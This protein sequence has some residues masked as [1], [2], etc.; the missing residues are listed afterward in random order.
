M[1]GRSGGFAWV[2]AWLGLAVA[3]AGCAAVLLPGPAYRAGWLELGSALGLFRGAVWLGLAAAVL[4]LLALVLTGLGGARRVLAVAVPAVVVGA[5][6]MVPPLHMRQIAASVPAI[7]DIT[8]D[9]DDPPAFVALSD[10]REAAP[11]ALEYP[12]EQVARQQREAY[13]DIR[14]RRYP[15]PYEEVFPRAHEAAAAMGWQLVA[16]ERDQGR[17]EAVAVTRWFGFRDDV[18]IR[19]R[20][21]ARETLVDV[22][23][24]S[25]IG[26]SDLGANAGRIRD[27][28]QRLDGLLDHA[29]ADSQ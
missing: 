17:I 7:H 4:G 20:Q 15:L 9:T 19:L 5:L 23:S 24:A 13:P 14:T 29:P 6:V 21:D 11:N 2:T 12:G 25:R 8:T 1:Q 26:R 22:R 18:V 28:L 27:Y 10:A 3:A 16:R